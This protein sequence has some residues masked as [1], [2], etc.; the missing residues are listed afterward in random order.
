[1][2]RHITLVM[3]FLCSCQSTILSHCWVLSFRQPTYNITNNFLSQVFF[4][5]FLKI[6]KNIF[7]PKF[8]DIMGFFAYN[9]Q[10]NKILG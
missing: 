8:L 9:P 10:K 7:L 3:L 2:F 1:L 5:G 6:F 4:K